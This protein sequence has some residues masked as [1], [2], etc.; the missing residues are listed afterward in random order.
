MIFFKI[1]TVQCEGNWYNFFQTIWAKCKERCFHQR[2]G[3]AFMACWPLSSAPQLTCYPDELNFA[4]G[5]LCLR[6]AQKKIECLYLRRWLKKELSQICTVW[7]VQVSRVRSERGAIPER[8]CSGP[9]MPALPHIPIPELQLKWSS[10]RIAIQ[11]IVC[12]ASFPHSSHQFLGR[13]TMEVITSW[14]KTTCHQ[15]LHQ[16]FP[17]SLFPYY[18]TQPLQVAHG[19]D[20]RS[21]A[22]LISLKMAIGWPLII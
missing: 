11:H 10:P 21:W 17:V 12:P 16:E 22:R 7:L 18:R 1:Q 9:W 8:R 4:L 14:R 19:S 3:A 2:G 20:C 13:V 15:H 5:A 6:N